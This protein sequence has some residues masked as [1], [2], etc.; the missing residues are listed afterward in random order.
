[1]QAKIYLSEIRKLD[2][3]ISN[4]QIELDALKALITSITPMM[5]E[6][7]VQSNGS[8]DRLGETMAKIIDLQREI[9]NKIDEYV[10]RKLEAIRLINLLE[11]DISI[12]ILIQRYIN[13]KQWDEIAESL[14]YTRQGIIK[15]HGQALL[16]F[17]KVYKRVDAS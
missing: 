17:E 7:N 3:K 13:Y 5:K 11:D 8:Q 10:D 15:K 2:R 4:K 1:M 16:D 14:S 12:S 9:N 6:I